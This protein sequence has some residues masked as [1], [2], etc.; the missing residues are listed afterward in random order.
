VGRW[1]KGE[2]PGD[3][4]QIVTSAGAFLCEI[5]NGQT[6]LVGIYD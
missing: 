3:Q 6:W 2:E 1:W 5:K 4:Y